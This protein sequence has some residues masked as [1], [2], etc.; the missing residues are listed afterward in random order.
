MAQGKRD[1]GGMK[2]AVV[3]IFVTPLDAEPA[4]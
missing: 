1:A 3:R 2:D 4:I